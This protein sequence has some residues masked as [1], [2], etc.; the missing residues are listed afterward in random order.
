LALLEAM[1]CGLAVISTDCPTGPA[2]II[3]DGVN[4]V[5]VPHNDVQG[6]ATAM[7]RLMASHS[8]RT[9]L[10]SRAVEI[11]ERYGIEKVMAL[12]DSLV[13]EAVRKG[14]QRTML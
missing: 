1:A 14:C 9:R 2:E 12:W 4:G 8:E 11:A 6:L 5:L 10:A 13:Q 7:D 3:Q